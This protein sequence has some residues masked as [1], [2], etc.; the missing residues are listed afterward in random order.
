MPTRS[1]FPRARTA[2]LLVDTINPFDFEGGAAFARRSIPTA[3][4][5][6]RLRDRARAARLPVIYVNDNFG[7]W[8]S[9]AAALV[10]W[11]R[12]SGRPGAPI[13]A[14]LAPR[15]TDYI[16]LKTTLSGFHQTPLE[17]MLRLGGVRT[18]I[19]C[20]FAADNCVLFTAADAYMRD[21]RLVVPRDCVAAKTPRALRS[22][23]RTMRSL[24]DADTRPSR[25]IR[26][27]RAISQSMPKV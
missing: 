17:T 19:V 9:D 7:R 14:I 11:C 10:R 3:R 6:A 24:F 22:A 27:S 25:R 13:V 8:R 12:R 5:I 26:M 1:H 20:G 23:L 21:Y 15:A 16:V 18:V 4:A 2:V